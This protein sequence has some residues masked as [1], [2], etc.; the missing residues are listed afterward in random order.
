ML[1]FIVSKNQF[2][3]V[4]YQHTGPDHVPAFQSNI[5]VWTLC[6]FHLHSPPL[7]FV[8]CLVH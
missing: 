5:S 7:F 3:A 2:L 1:Q 8:A 6:V 4:I